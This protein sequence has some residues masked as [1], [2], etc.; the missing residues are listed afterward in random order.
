VLTFGLWYWLIDRGGPHMRGR[1]AGGHAEFL[2]PEM[3]AEDADPQWRPGLGE[4][5]DLA[6]TNA[7]AFSP[8]DTFPLSSRAMR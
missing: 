7:T 1:H 2:F 4:Y 3:T 8:T 5:M 6:F